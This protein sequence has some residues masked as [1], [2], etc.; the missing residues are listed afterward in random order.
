MSKARFNRLFAFVVAAVVLGPGIVRAD[1]PPIVQD[2]QERLLQSPQVATA[3]AA[4]P[5]VAAPALAQFTANGRVNVATS[6]G[7]CATSALLSSCTSDCLQLQI[8]GPLAASSPVGKSTLAACLT[9]YLPSDVGLCY[10]EQG[11]GTITATNGATLKFAT[12]GKMCFSDASSSFDLYITEGGFTIE[13]GTGAFVTA[14][15]EG[16]ISVPLIITTSGIATGELNM[17]GSYAKQ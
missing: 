5:Q 14:V 15:G 2:A 6:D 17:I 11:N 1:P 7:G 12:G 16:H 9:L 4:A 8:S 10:D 13:G 3:N